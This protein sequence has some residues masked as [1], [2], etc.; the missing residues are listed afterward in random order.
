MCLFTE[1]EKGLSVRLENLWPNKQAQ[2][3]AL[4]TALL[5]YYQSKPELRAK[6]GTPERLFQSPD[7]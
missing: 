2:M 4:N 7:C 1:S 5:T 3:F 6:I